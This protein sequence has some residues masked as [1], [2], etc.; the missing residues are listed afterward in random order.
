M[1]TQSGKGQLALKVESTNFRQDIQGLRGLAVL[2]VVAYHA[3]LPIPGGFVGVDMFFVISGMVVT[4]TV[5]R[6]VTTNSFSIL[7]FYSKST[8]NI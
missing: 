3:Q 8:A 1:E 7:N 4:K 5:I 2:A 6:Q